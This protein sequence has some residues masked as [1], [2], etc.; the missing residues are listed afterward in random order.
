MKKQHVQLGEIDRQYLES[1]LATGEL[2][3]K[4][5]RRALAL[6]E[7]DHS[8]FAI[9]PSRPGEKTTL[10]KACYVSTMACVLVAP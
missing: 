10:S 1:L 4:V 8:A 2:P 3:V 6:L 7:L 5:Y 9:A